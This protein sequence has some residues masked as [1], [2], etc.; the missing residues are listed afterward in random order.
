MVQISTPHLEELRYAKRLLEKPSLAAKLTDTLGTPIEKGFSLLP[1]KWSETIREAIHNSLYKGLE[2]AV[3][4]LGADTSRPARERFH[5]LAIITAG[6][7]GGAF[8]L[9][10]LLVELPFST[11]IILRSIAD[12][13]RSE[14]EDIDC[15]EARLACL[16]VFA[17]GGRSKSDDAAETGYFAIRSALAKSV[18]EAARHI[19][20]KGFVEEGAPALV[21]FISA[22]ASRFGI[23]VS[24]K[25]AAM[26]VPAIGAAGGAL[27]NSIFINH[28]QDTAR[29]HFTVRRL[30]RCYDKE[31]V[32]AEY[33]KLII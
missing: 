14:G 2:V 10:G 33:Q 22:V 25:V 7:T 29:G 8:G 30:E 31:L 9:A 16:E 24:E 18:S 4:S 26:A 1:E 32:Q 20:E 28:F 3:K 27:I 6:A 19:A 21:R 13:A 12:I 23:A 5:K 15:I 11:T 17:L